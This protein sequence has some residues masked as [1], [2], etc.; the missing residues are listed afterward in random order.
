MFYFDKCQ[1]C[2]MWVYGE[3]CDK[4][5]LSENRKVRCSVTNHGICNEYLI[6]FFLVSTVD[7]CSNNKTILL[8]PTAVLSGLA[9]NRLTVLHMI[10][11]RVNIL[12][13][14]LLYV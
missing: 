5:R 10:N 4:A 14:F 6:T 8:K 9:V 12:L 3:W 1:I 11:C 13:H 2:K 7:H